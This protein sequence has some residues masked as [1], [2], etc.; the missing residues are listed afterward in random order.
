MWSEKNLG[1]V[2]S[3]KAHLVDSKISAA[4]KQNQILL[5]AVSRK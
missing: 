5:M 4:S 2:I 1:R 3:A